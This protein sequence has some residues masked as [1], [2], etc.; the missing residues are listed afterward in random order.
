M[1]DQPARAP[2]PSMAPAV[3]GRSRRHLAGR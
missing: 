2:T 1:A 3:R